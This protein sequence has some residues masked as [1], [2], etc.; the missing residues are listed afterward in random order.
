MKKFQ[1]HLNRRYKYSY[2]GGEKEADTLGRYK[3]EITGPDGSRLEID[4][5]TIRSV[6]RLESVRR[7]IGY[8][9]MGQTENTIYPGGFR[10]FADNLFKSKI[11]PRTLDPMMSSELRR[12]ICSRSLFLSCR[13]VGKPNPGKSFNMAIPMELYLL[14]VDD[15]ITADMV[16]EMEDHEKDALR[17]N[18]NL[19]DKVRLLLELV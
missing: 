4:T 1:R 10:T 9:A 19:S 8:K 2:E 3:F 11:E 12:H 7:E 16:A 13:T 18:K 14:A 6:L 5:E 17:L 15:R